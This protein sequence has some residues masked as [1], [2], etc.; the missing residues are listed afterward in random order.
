MALF[1]ILRGNKSALDSQEIVEGRVWVT[2]D[3]H[4]MY[5]DIKNDQKD[6][7]R[8]KLYDNLE[9]DIVNLKNEVAT[10]VKGLTNS[11]NN[12][13]NTSV[14]P[15]N[16]GEIKTKY[17]VAQKG[18]TSGATWYYPL[19]ELPV[20][21]TGNYASVIAVGRLGGWTSDNMSYISALVWNRDTPGITTID[22][23]G[24]AGAS[25]T[26][27]NVADLVL[28]VN[29]T[30]A[31]AAATATLYAK[32]TGYFVFDLNLELFQSTGKIIYDGSYLTATPTGTL[33]AQASTTAQRVEIIN[34]KLS[35]GGKDVVLVDEGN[36]GSATQLKTAVNING[37]SFD[38]TKDIVTT[39]WG[40]SRAVQTQDNA[41]EHTSKSITWDG[42]TNIKIYLPETIKGN[43]I[44]SLDGNASNA[45]KATQ[46]ANG[47][48]I[49]D[50]YETK[51]DSSNKLVVAKKYTDDSISPLSTKVTT[52]IGSD[53]GK[54][55]RKIANE[56][57]AAQLIPED[58]QESLN[59]LKEIADWIQNHPKDAAAMNTA[60]SNKVDKTTV[61]AK[62]PKLAW[63]STS[64]IGTIGDVTFNVTMPTNP[65]THYVTKLYTGASATN[66]NSA[67]TDPYIKVIDDTTYRNQI[68]I[69]GDGAT[70]VTSDS[71][72]VITIKSTNT[73]Y[74]AL[75]NPY[76]L[77]LQVNGS[78]LTTYD[79]SKA[80]TFNVPAASS[81]AAGVVTTGQ[82]T[83]AGTKT[84]VYPR[85]KASSQYAGI[86]YQ[87][88]SGNTVVNNFVNT[89]SST[90][91]TAN[92][93]TWRFYSYNSSTPSTAPLSYY[94]QYSLPA[95]TADRTA[96]A[97]Y[98]ILTTKNYL[99]YAAKVTQNVF[100][101]SAIGSTTLPVYYNG[102]KLAVCDS[103]LEVDISGNAVSA[104][105]LDTN[106]G[107][108]TLPVYFY[109]GIPV[110]C[111]TTLDVSITGNAATATKV[112]TATV[113]GT[114]KPI[115]LKAG[116]P[117][118]CSSTIGGAL[119][120]AYMRS[121]TITACTMS[122]SGDR[123]GVLPVVDSD[124]Y[125]ATGKYLD[126][127]GSDGATAKAFELSA[128][129]EVLT[130]SGKLS[131]ST[132][133]GKWLSGMDLT[134][135]SININTQQITDS[136][137]P[138]INVKTSGGNYVSYGGIGDNV[139][140]YGY[141]SRRTVNGYDW[142]VR[143]TAATGEII[144]KSYIDNGARY[145]LQGTG[146]VCFTVQNTDTSNRVGLLLGSG[147]YN[148]GVYDFTND[149]W[150][151]WVDSNNHYN[152]GPS[153]SVYA[154][155]SVLYGA[156]WND[157]AEFRAKEEIIE[158]GYCVASRDDGK[159]YKT[160]EKFQ[161][162]DGIVSDTYGFVIGDQENETIP[163]A[164]AGRVLAYCE[165]NRYSYHAGDTVCAGPGGK[166]VKMT[167][168]E[169]CMWP[170]RIIGIVSEIPEYETWGKNNVKVN[171][172]IW[173]KVR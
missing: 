99:D 87:N 14:M 106:A 56:E 64:E 89:G 17:R 147:G 120:P 51:A 145:A 139:G 121:G 41:G 102:T 72:G 141:L 38:G 53:S 19:C 8:I 104:S 2:K 74:S 112:G 16:N 126:F 57:L 20:N 173:I 66:S 169:I 124:G 9:N 6:S 35:V 85:V 138:I 128:E 94:E 67:T 131:L 135:A 5:V 81:S 90:N 79:G 105:K 96:N 119:R 76:A 154:Y 161:A 125:L 33:T 28:Y 117:T 24:R 151:F 116:A 150:A 22:L 55:V 129:N 159:V 40:T 21:N 46:D 75:K 146:N 149:N 113:G 168:E 30:S 29:S 97:S 73:T 45:T 166:V 59:T 68:Q 60:I 133:P 107:S 167:R 93:M 163:L 39:K 155:N 172:R 110:A 170:D 77:T 65:N 32:C 49:A 54:S 140:F 48:V 122:A 10:S 63:N 171:G 37:T 52:L 80:Y 62:N 165:G 153:G 130:A 71:S 42:S 160:T 11:L 47:K 115:Y 101:S 34:G 58:A 43:F 118:A 83:F 134:G 156:C 111:S 148:R 69:K 98:M 61:T 18:N 25:S 100:G 12:K 136:Y 26:V 31:T 114:A 84:F 44:G 7:V 132:F 157:Y 95:M 88:A 143:A 127:Y 144:H 70:T 23:G 4:A 137:H 92:Q 86:I 152:V 50:T 108:S 15:N 27:Y 82:Q 142:Y 164:V 109:D 158:P 36:A 1:K 3:E 123:W 91:I 13:T 103:T 78:P 162:C